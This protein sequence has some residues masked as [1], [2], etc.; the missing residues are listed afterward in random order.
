[1]Q[2]PAVVVVTA[3]APVD[4]RVGEEEEEGQEEEE[5]DDNNEGRWEH[6]SVK[7]RGAWHDAQGRRVRDGTGW[8]DVL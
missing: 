4:R 8:F 1:M 5:D 6:A 2:I 3:V 7:W